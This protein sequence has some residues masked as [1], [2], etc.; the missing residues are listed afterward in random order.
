MLCVYFLHFCKLKYANC[1]L[2]TFLHSLKCLILLTFNNWHSKCTAL[3]HERDAPRNK[4]RKRNHADFPRDIFGS[5]GVL[6][7]DHRDKDGNARLYS[8]SQARGDRGVMPLGKAKEMDMR[9]VRGQEAIEYKRIHPDAELNKRTDPTEEERFDIDLEYADEV[10]R[11]DA[12]LLY[13]E[14]DD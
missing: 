14:L 11:E 3:G 4:N 2:F 13:V 1:A 8:G 5:A 12:G 6:A 10:A 9:I 7:G